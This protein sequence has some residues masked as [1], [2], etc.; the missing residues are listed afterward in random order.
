MKRTLLS[1]VFAATFLTPFSSNVCASELGN[2]LVSFEAKSADEVVLSGKIFTNTSQGSVSSGPISF[3]VPTGPYMP[4]GP[5]QTYPSML[6]IILN[7]IATWSPELGP[8]Q[9]P[10]LIGI[11]NGNEIGRWDLLKNG[12]NNFIFADNGMDTR[13]IESL[14]AA[15]KI[16]LISDDSNAPTSSAE[17]TLTT[18]E[19]QASPIISVEVQGSEVEVI[20]EDGRRKSF[21]YSLKNLKP[22]EL[23][24]F[25]AKA[26]FELNATE[27]DF[28]RGVGETTLKISAK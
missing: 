9:V 24:G 5:M 13:T 3:S 4:T 2:G 20:A 23:N 27:V 16:N 17:F 8:Q 1:A 22:T 7:F 21:P 11:V 12:A 15:F 18:N 25:L 26:A 10:S 6:E 28:H 19:K 14:G